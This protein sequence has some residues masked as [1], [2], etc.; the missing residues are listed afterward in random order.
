VTAREWEAPSATFTGTTLGPVT[1]G[2]RG[3]QVR[4]VYEW[5]RGECTDRYV[6]V[7]RYRDE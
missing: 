2:E 4:A 3:E 6:T 5:K 1:D 7:V